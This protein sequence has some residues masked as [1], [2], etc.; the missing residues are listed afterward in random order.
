MASRSF[1]RFEYGRIFFFLLYEGKSGK[2]PPTFE[3]KKTVNIFG[4]R[5]HVSVQLLRANGVSVKGDF[6]PAPFWQAP[7][8]E[9]NRNRK[10][11]TKGRGRDEKRVEAEVRS[12]SNL[13][14]KIKV[15]ALGQL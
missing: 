11:G 9:A 5:L 4:H 7:R 15:P 8:L 1:L 13:K 6:A 10:P 14:T 2:L 12:Q 3:A